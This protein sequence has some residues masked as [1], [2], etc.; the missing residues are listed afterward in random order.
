MGED[1]A[2]TVEAEATARGNDELASLIEDAA[3]RRVAR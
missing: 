1:G 3:S 2:Y